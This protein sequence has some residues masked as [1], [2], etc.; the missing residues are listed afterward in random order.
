[1]ISIGSDR[2]FLK[3]STYVGCDTS[4]AVA[5]F[6][7]A[8]TELLARKSFSAFLDLL[9]YLKGYDPVSTSAA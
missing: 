2:F 9:H 3:K 4:T 8:L 6:T 7:E 5:H 1:M